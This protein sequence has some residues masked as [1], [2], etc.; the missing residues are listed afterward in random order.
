M[1]N[2]PDEGHCQTHWRNDSC[3][4]NQ[5]VADRNKINNPEMKS[6]DSTLQLNCSLINFLGT[7][8][9]G[10][11]QTCLLQAEENKPS[12]FLFFGAANC[13][14]LDASWNTN[15]PPLPDAHTTSRNRV[16]RGCY[17]TCE[18]LFVEPSVNSS[19]SQDN[20]AIYSPVF[21][22]KFV[23]LLSSS[24]FC[25]ITAATSF[26][27]NRLDELDFPE[28][29]SNEMMLQVWSRPVVNLSHDIWDDNRK[30]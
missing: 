4:Y 2:C 26:I 21:L 30:K 14:V 7:K 22:L 23:C 11:H 10:N 13:L 18:R 28:I 1:W 20:K 12:W 19:S 6:H 3:S 29:K 27:R 25:F 16:A 5:Y 9:A 8:T 15:W 17:S 24:V